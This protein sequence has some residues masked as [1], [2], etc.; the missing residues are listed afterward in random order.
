[1]KDKIFFSKKGS[2]YQIGKKPAYYIIVLL[3]LVISF[4]LF[5]SIIMSEVSLSNSIPNNVDTTVLVNRFLNS[6]DCFAY[7]DNETG[8]IY[9]GIIDIKK[10]NEDTLKECYNAGSN[11]NSKSFKFIIKGSGIEEKTIFT[12][13]WG[14]RK[15]S[16]VS[17]Y[18]LIYNKGKISKAN[19]LIAVQEWNI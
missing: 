9:P 4:M 5:G 19:L 2:G 11:Y 7:K 12:I 15:F 8:R 18:V 14:A 1:M 16:Q 6:D 13:N 17:Q 3:F 10:F